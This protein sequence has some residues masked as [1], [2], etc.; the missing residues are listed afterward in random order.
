MASNS[1]QPSTPQAWLRL[2]RQFEMR[3]RQS[4]SFQPKSVGRIFGCQKSNFSRPKL[5]LVA[6]SQFF[7][8]T[9]QPWA[10]NKLNF[11][12][13]NPFR[14]SKFTVFAAY[15]KIRV[16]KIKFFATKTSLGDKNRIF[17]VPNQFGASKI[18][19]FAARQIWGVRNRIS[20]FPN[21]F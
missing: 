10:L 12:V 16:S 18:D 11:H 1:E 3:F 8:L 4:T 6:T 20:L 21:K 17:H 9:N 5:N 19:F 2:A 7:R 15:K 14:V 13:P